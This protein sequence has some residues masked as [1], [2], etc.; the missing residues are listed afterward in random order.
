[1][2]KGRRFGFFGQPANPVSEQSG[3]ENEVISLRSQ[4][5]EMQNKL[6]KLELRSKE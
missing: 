4:L 6:E 1:M 5:E 3:L 2:R